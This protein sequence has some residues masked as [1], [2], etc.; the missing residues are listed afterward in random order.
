[1][2]KTKFLGLLSICRKSGRVTFGFDAVKKSMSEHKSAAVFLTSDI[3][4]KTEKEIR[5]FSHEK[6]K[7]FKTDFSMDDIYS[8]TGKKSAVFSVNDRGFSEK[9]CEYIA[10]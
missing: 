2:N 8:A 6:I 7:I 9:L 3:S 5:F 1:M 10:D 4:P